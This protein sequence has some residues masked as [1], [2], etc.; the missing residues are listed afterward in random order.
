MFGGTYVNC[1]SLCKYILFAYDF[2]H[3]IEN[4]KQSKNLKPVFRIPLLQ[5]KWLFM[6]LT[7]IFIY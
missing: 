4:I 7:V 6:K 5:Y 3:V 1:I 2:F